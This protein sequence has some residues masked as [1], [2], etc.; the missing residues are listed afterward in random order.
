M[1]KTHIFEQN[2][3]P[4]HYFTDLPTLYFLDRYRKQ[5]TFF[6]RPETDLKLKALYIGKISVYDDHCIIIVLEVSSD[7][8]C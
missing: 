8:L 3:N 2:N 1:Y 5:T 7:R 6:S 4:K